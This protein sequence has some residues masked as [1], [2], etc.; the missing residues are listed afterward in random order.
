M[1]TNFAL[2][3]SLG[4]SAKKYAPRKQPT[5]TNEFI[6][7]HIE[8]LGGLSALQRELGADPQATILEFCATELEETWSSWQDDLLDLGTAAAISG[9]SYSTIEKRVRS[10][11]IPNSGRK[12]KP[13]VRRQ[14]LPMRKPQPKVSRSGSEPDLAGEVLLNQV[15]QERTVSS[16]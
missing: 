16:A 13:L 3:S 15:G 6:A 8:L 1:N 2:A 7:N 12:G 5:T 10:G 9:V 4:A 14:D 11:A